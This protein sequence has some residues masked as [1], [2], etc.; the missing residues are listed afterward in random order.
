MIWILYWVGASLIFGGGWIIGACLNK[1]KIGDQIR[2]I[3]EQES[4]NKIL[5][6]LLEVLD[7]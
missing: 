7:L 2:L 4:D 3:A 5:F 6:K 1:R